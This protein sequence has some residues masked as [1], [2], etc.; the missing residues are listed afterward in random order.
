MSA[1]THLLTGAVRRALRRPLT[2]AARTYLVLLEKRLR[3]LARLARGASLG[4]KE[5]AALAA[6]R[7]AAKRFL[8]GLESSWDDGDENLV[9]GFLDRWVAPAA[10]PVAA[11]ARGLTEGALALGRIQTRRGALFFFLWEME[12]VLAG[13]ATPRRGPQ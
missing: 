12:S 10:D 13:L 6:G 9:R 5:A 8:R 3:L 4:P 1:R 11:A 7:T 2:P